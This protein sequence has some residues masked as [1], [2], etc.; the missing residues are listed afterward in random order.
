MPTDV[1]I[2]IPTKN[3]P[4]LLDRLL[5][6]INEQSFLNNNK[7]RCHIVDSSSNNKTNTMVSHWMDI[8]NRNLYID[9]EFNGND[10]QPIDNWAL[11][12]NK[13]S[14]EYSK[15]MCDDDWLVDNALDEFMKNMDE[16]I[17]CIISNINLCF[18]N[19][20]NNV[21]NYYDLATGIVEPK[22]VLDSFLGLKSS[23]PVT[24]SASLLRSDSLVES[25]NFSFKNLD[26][27]NRL[28]GEDLTL[29]YFFAF[30]D[31]SS[32][33]IK[34]ALVNSW[35]GKDSLTLNSNL[36]ILTYCNI[37][38]LDL[39]AEEFN[40][41]YTKEQKKAIQHYLFTNN[42]KRVFN[43]DY[44]DIKYVGL[45]KPFPSFKKLYQFSKKKF[46]SFYKK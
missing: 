20:T 34:K 31:K 30:K 39:L 41:K 9:Y 38:S 15:F 35:A 12:L 44:G 32:L 24:Q 18:K 37:L 1:S 26:C 21:N 3:R 2:L 45:L 43:K 13:I 5:N 46:Y 6:S 7:I 8:S 10:F 16:S 40:F 4:V 17:S 11:L 36:S 25:F 33:H 19:K 28:F 22:N 27:T 14:T 29:N 23:I 42:L